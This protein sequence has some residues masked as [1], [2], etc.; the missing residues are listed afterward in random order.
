MVVS[1]GRRVTLVSL[2]RWA[3]LHVLQLG[4]GR[5]AGIEVSLGHGNDFS[6]GYS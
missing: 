3:L 2:F 1:A 4:L 6:E 5:A